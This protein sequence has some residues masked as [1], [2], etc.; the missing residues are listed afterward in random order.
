MRGLI[1][2]AIAIHGALW[3]AIVLGDLLAQLASKL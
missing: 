2:F 3:L 1:S